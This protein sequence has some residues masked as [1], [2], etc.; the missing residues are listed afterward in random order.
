MAGYLGSYRYEKI[1]GRNVILAAPQDV[2]LGDLVRESLEGTPGAGVVRPSDARYVVHSTVTESGKKIL[3]DGELRSYVFLKSEGFM[4]EPRLGHKGLEEPEDFLD[5]INFAVWTS[6]WPEAVISSNQKNRFVTLDEA[7][8]P[9]YRFYFDAHKIIES[10]RAV[11]TGSAIF[12][13]QRHLPLSDFLITCLT[14]K[15]VHNV[16]DEP[17]TPRRFSEEANALFE[18]RL[19]LSESVE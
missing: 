10:G 16:S 3:Q 2:N 17:W 6:P 15:D 19:Q 18:D 7:Y 4:K 9:G 12:A 5:L 1:V 11:R 14:A 8:M 13:V